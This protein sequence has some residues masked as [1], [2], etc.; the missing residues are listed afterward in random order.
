MFARPTAV[1]YAVQ[2]PPFQSG[3]WKLRKYVSASFSGENNRKWYSLDSSLTE[4]NVGII[5]VSLLCESRRLFRAELSQ[6]FHSIN[7]K[8]KQRIKKRRCVR[9][10][11]PCRSLS[12][13]PPMPVVSVD[14]Y[15]WTSRREERA[16]WRAQPYPSFTAQ[17]PFS[18]FPCLALSL[19]A[20]L[21]VA[22]S[23]RSN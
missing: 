13:G 4:R 16:D 6:K 12:L 20:G 7:K 3:S 21:P 14:W 15:Y 10:R 1:P 2:T 18:P 19:P 23:L 17:P 22:P 5:L 11:C 9:R 8:E